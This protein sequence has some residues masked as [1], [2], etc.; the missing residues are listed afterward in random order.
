MS[1]T[2]RL[3]GIATK[4]LKENSNVFATFLVKNIKACIKRREFPDKL[5]TAEFTPAFK[6]G[7]EHDKSN[8]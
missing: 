6:K 3:E 2:T 1:K 4:I 7:D 5:K 8:Y